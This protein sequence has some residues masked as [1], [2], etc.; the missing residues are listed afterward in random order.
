MDNV[1]NDQEPFPHIQFSEVKMH[2]EWDSSKAIPVLI[3]MYWRGMYADLQAL[4]DSVVDPNSLEE[5]LHTY[6]MYVRQTIP[7]FEID[8][9][10]YWDRIIQPVSLPFSGPYFWISHLSEAGTSDTGRIA[11][12][13]AE[14]ITAHARISSNQLRGYTSARIDGLPSLKDLGLLRVHDLSERNNYAMYCWLS[15]EDDT[16]PEIMHMLKPFN[17]RKPATQYADAEQAIF[18]IVPESTRASTVICLRDVIVKIIPGP[19]VYTKTKKTYY[20]LSQYSIPPTNPI[21]LNATVL[22][23]AH[24]KSMATRIAIARCIF[25]MSMKEDAWLGAYYE[26][27]QLH[28]CSINHTAI[29][30]NKSTQIP[31]ELKSMSREDK[32]WLRALSN[33]TR[34]TGETQSRV[35]LDQITSELI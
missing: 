12:K 28:V 17:A 20:T 4:T 34:I 10:H 13:S 27:G 2:D 25:G 5:W 26:N 9:T 32:A 29:F 11:R 1:M 16:S 19:H 15:D 22:G 18:S 8:I 6:E 3:S 33:N 7:D 35:R 21:S 31:K 30:S 23:N 24:L 14:E